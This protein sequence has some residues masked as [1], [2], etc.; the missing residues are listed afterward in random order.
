MLRLECYPVC[1]GIGVNLMPFGMGL[2]GCL[3][4]LGLLSKYFIDSNSMAQK[5][6]RN[7]KAGVEIRVPL[8]LSGEQFRLFRVLV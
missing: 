5:N 2:L 7:L 6:K 8:F 3:K 1:Q 4:F